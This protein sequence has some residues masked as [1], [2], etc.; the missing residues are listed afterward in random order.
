MAVVGDVAS[1]K[2]AVD[3]KGAGAFASK[4]ELKTALDATKGDH[5]GFVFIAIRPLV[6][7]STQLSGS[8]LPG[9]ALTELIPDW[10]AFSLRVEGDGLVMEA[11]S[12]KAAGAPAVDARTSVVADHVPNN[13]VALTISQ[14]YG[15][16]ILKTLDLYR[17]DP[18]LKP[19]IDSIDQAIGVLGGADAAIGW[20]GDLG[21]AVTHTDAGLEGGVVIVP[22]DRAAAERLFTSLRTLVSVGGATLGVSVRDEAYAG[23][24]ITIV[25]L[26][27]V[28]DLVARSGVSPDMLGTT[29]LPTGHI[30]L[31]YAI[32]DQVVILGADP[33][34]VRHVLDT[35]AA[36]SLASNDRYK[37]LVARVGQG[38][39]VGF[40]DIT[41]I[42]ELVESALA[43]ADAAELADYEQ[44]VKPF[45][46][47]LDAVIAS[48]SAN[49][50]INHSTLI[51]TVK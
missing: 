10:G 5:I 9:G 14:D 39:G 37:A 29:P 43:N 2:A 36:T 34:F 38:T 13:A 4:P 32:T 1:V 7:W 35:T 18:S 22:T 30:E 6:E 51:V 27:T 23:T 28:A 44:N 48:A 12:A 24:T 16:G 19:T 47:P 50:D 40:A 25:D 42:R 46:V 31:A 49:G 3:T 11:I 17:A 15:K 33:G 41:A 20:I 8:A 45:L 21:I 26:G